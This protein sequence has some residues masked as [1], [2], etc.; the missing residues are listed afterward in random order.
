MEFEQ[1]ISN[2]EY[3]GN[4][5]LV[6]LSIFYLDQ[7]EEIDEVSSREVR[8]LIDQ[9]RLSVNSDS[10]YT[11]IGRLSDSDLLTD[12]GNG[13]ILSLEGLEKFGE[14][15][16]D[17]FSDSQ[18]HS[19][20][21]ISIETDHEFYEPLLNSLNTAFQAGLYDTVNILSRKTLEN[22]LIDI[23]RE[24]YGLEE[25]EKFYNP[26]KNKF[27]TFY[28]LIQ[29]FD[30]DLEELKPLSTAI[31]QETVDD[32]HEFREEGNIGAH[33]I[34]TGISKGDLLER[35]D[36]FQHLFRVL[37]DLRKKLIREEK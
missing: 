23:F 32:L 18:N 15:A 36:D 14:K 11:Y 27:K 12:K 19:Q 3:S 26:N 5:E 37:N 34:K 6:G 7:I 24:K 22:L 9:S 20:K 4:K 30:S 31:R 13:Y 35:S 28:Q 16:A 10:I 2:S 17:N 29:Q 25:S 33:S 8:E 1:F 21:Y